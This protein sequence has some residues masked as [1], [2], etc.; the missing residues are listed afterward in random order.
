MLSRKLFAIIYKIF[1]RTKPQD[2][3]S[4]GS[5]E[6]MSRYLTHRD[7]FPRNIIRHSAFMPPIRNP[8]TS[9]YWISGI[10]DEEVW[11]I[12]NTHVAPKR[13]PIL[14]RADFNSLTVYQTGLAI[15]LT[16]IP[17]PRH[18]DIIHWD[19]D[20]KKAKLQAMKLA[21]AAIFIAVP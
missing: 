18:A 16:R 15:D 19:Q 6:T 4:S 7:E 17:H 14:G 12:G 21:D 10:A 13:G 1:S 8:R 3:F 2:P 20:R 11:N 9:V 5:G